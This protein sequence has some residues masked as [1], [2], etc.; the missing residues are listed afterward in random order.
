MTQRIDGTRDLI[1]TLVTANHI[2]YDQ[3]VVD[4]FG[5]VSVRDDERDDRFFLARSMAPADVEREDIL[6]FG[7][8]GE[9]VTAKSENVYL[10]RYIHSEI[11]KARPDV[12]SIVHSHSHSIVPFSVLNQVP[13]RPLCHMAGF[14]GARAPVFEIRDDF[15]DNTDLLVRDAKRGKALADSI[16]DHTIV[17]MRGHGSTVVADSIEKAVFR[18]I[19]AEV[20]A[21]LQLGASVLGDVTFLSEAE[22]G[23]CMRVNESQVFRPWELW[24][25]RVRDA[26]VGSR[27]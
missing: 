13:L 10:E 5:H 23:E 9:A 27:Q 7:L 19:Y 1:S 2:L 20:N 16:G 11:Y 4:G 17:L 8:D 14:I 15:G 3:G 18:A 26:R 12:R 6:E 22:A 24:M 25:R 21:R